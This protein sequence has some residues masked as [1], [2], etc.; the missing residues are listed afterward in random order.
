MSADSVRA[1]V[2]EAARSVPSVTRPARRARVVLL[3]LVSLVA[4]VAIFLVRGGIRPTGRPLSLIFVTATGAATLN[5]A[6]VLAWLALSNVTVPGPLTLVHVTLTVLAAG[7]PSSVTAPRRL[8]GDG[9]MTGCGV[10]A[11]TP[12]AAL[13]PLFQ[14]ITTAFENV[15]A[16]LTRTV[17]EGALV[18]TADQVSPGSQIETLLPSGRLISRVEDVD[19]NGNLLTA[20]PTNS[21]S[22]GSRL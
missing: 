4:S 8:A 1:S 5:A 18:R 16:P 7:R 13:V 22:D 3:L 21:V 15:S 6:E 11:L 19:P 17:P 2:L 12:G 10:P 14:V 20:T 9:R